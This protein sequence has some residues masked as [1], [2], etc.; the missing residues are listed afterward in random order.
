[1]LVAHQRKMF[2]RIWHPLHALQLTGPRHA[3]HKIYQTSRIL[4]YCS[5]E[6]CR[7]QGVSTRNHGQSS[8][9]CK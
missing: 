4:Q 2:E 6:H 5:V 9:R 1:M 8:R 7:G 3:G